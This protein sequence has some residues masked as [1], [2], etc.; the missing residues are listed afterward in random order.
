ME[1]S[2]NKNWVELDWSYL[3]WAWDL[4]KEWQRTLSKFTDKELLD[5]FPEAGATIPETLAEWGKEQDELID[6]IKKKL[7][8]IRLSGVDEGT[9]WFWQEWTKLNDGEKLL[10]IDN[11][12]SR[13]KRLL[14]TA[15]GQAPPK[16]RITQEQIDQA[17]SVPIG[18]LIGQPLRKSGKTLVGLCPLHNEKHPSF[19]IYPETNRW[20][21]YGGCGQ[22]GDVIN[23][24]ELLHNYSFKEAVQYL[25]KK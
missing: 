13:L 19:Y 9:K 16:G 8:V 6:K 4:E 22:G 24:V 3:F 12:I 18:N 10:E 20:W 15:K 2:Q 23:L 11:H 25:I 21:C 17:L 14:W 1:I 7:T 5:I